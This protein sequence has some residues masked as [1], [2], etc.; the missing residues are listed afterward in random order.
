[1]IITIETTL[2]L[3]DLGVRPAV[4]TGEVRTRY[5][6]AAPEETYLESRVTRVSV[7]L[8]PD[9]GIE[10]TGLLSKS[11]TATLEEELEAEYLRVTQGGKDE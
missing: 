3:G 11:A 7:A 5:F 6:A 1:M 4:L 2:D 8:S 9:R 10:V